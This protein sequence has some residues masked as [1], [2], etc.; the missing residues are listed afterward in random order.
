MGFLGV[1][2][3]LRGNSGSALDFGRLLSDRDP[4]KPD[5]IKRHVKNSLRLSA[6]TRTGVKITRRRVEL[7][8]YL[9]PV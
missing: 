7:L 9:H 6:T 8:R 1:Q 5:L 4:K 3:S 2:L